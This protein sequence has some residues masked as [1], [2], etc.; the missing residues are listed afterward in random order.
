M[1]G[2]DNIDTMTF[3]EHN[4]SAF[5][6]SDQLWQ[7]HTA[8]AIIVHAVEKHLQL[9]QGQVQAQCLAENSQL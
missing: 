9:L 6:E 7:L 1:I 8:V 5:Q 4:V 2:I 3:K